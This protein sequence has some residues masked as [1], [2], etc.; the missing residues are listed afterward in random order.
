MIGSL[1]AEM[2]SPES[3]LRKLSA[4][5]DPDLIA[6]AQAGAALLGVDIG[7]FTLLS[8]RRFAERAD[9]EAWTTL[10]SAMNRSEDPGSE[11]LRMI[12]RRAADDV[13]SALG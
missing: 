10:M 9:A 5:D 12:L 6:D 2:E 13:R 7:R 11:A 8:V 4:V 3:V 1:L